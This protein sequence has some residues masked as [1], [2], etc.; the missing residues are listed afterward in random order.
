MPSICIIGDLK[1]GYVDATTA[2]QLGAYS[3]CKSY[4]SQ[5]PLPPLDEGLILRVNEDRCEPIRIPSK[6]LKESAELFLCALKLYRDGVISGL[7]KPKDA[8][9]YP[10]LMG[11]GHVFYPRVTSI[12]KVL[13]REMLNQWMVKQ[14]VKYT[15]KE[16]IAHK[17]DAATTLELYENGLF[18]P[19]QGAFKHRDS[20]GTE[21]RDL[22]RLVHNYLTGKPISL[23]Q[24]SIWVQSAFRKFEA[25]AKEVNLTL[26]D[27]LAETK[28][29]SPDYQFAGT[30]DYVATMEVADATENIP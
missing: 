27:G 16:M 11:A 5:Q 14:S 30:L 19:Q 29:Y 20:R 7:I 17:R 2:Y 22:H 28:I 3:L 26:V 9:I 23:D 24:E 6:R 18:D 15:L 10:L 1:T 4:T 21:G 25:W 12:L 13:N 8:D